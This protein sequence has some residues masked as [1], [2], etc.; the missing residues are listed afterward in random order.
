MAFGAKLIRI[1]PKDTERLSRSSFSSLTYNVEL[2]D[3]SGSGTISGSM[4]TFVRRN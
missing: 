4:P 2:V 3:E 1:N